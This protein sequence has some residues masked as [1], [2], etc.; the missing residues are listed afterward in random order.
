MAVWGMA[1]ETLLSSI[2]RN[3]KRIL[4]LI[5]EDRGKH[6]VSSELKHLCKKY[7]V[8][9]SDQLM[10]SVILMENYYKKI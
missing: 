2:I 4:K 10:K 7:K 3:Q 1:S 6:C 8:L 5:D 9:P